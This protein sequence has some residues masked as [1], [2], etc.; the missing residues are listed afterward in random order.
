MQ[1]IFNNEEQNQLQL[2]KNVG[3]S[4]TETPSISAGS[5]SSR[6]EMS[7]GTPPTGEQYNGW[8][9]VPYIPKYAKGAVVN[10]LLQPNNRGRHNKFLANSRD[11]SIKPEMSSGY[12]SSLCPPP[13]P[14]PH[15]PEKTADIWR[16]HHWF[17]RDIVTYPGGGGRSGE[18]TRRGIFTVDFNTDEYLF[19]FHAAFSTERC[20]KIL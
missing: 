7:C 1:E 19:P 16:R 2:T 8:M 6:A 9:I 14:S 10:S 17:P 20:Y 12:P 4:P 11:T 18:P 15:Q 13:P 3:K 5:I